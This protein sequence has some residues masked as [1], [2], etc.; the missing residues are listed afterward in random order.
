MRP[1]HPALLVPWLEANAEAM[2]FIGQ[3]TITATGWDGTG[4]EGD[5]WKLCDASLAGPGFCGCLV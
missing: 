4:V 1:I 2:I 5:P 3:E